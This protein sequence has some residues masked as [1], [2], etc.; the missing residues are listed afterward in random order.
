LD[1]AARQSTFAPRPASRP[2]FNSRPR[3][4]FVP[5]NR[6]LDGPRERPKRSRSYSGRDVNNA[7]TS[8][9]RTC[10][11]VIYKDFFLTVTPTLLSTGVSARVILTHCAKVN[12]THLVAAFAAVRT[13]S[14]VFSS[15]I[16]VPFA[17][18]RYRQNH[19]TVPA[20]RFSRHRDVTVRI[21]VF[22]VIHPMIEVERS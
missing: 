10:N 13:T 7:A 17:L 1:A 14:A 22:P 20:R 6:L 19:L 15:S 11:P 18:F 16:G 21:T 4:A 2:G 3:P 5:S 8:S 12:V 9:T